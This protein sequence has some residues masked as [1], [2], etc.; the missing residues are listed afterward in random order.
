MA[1]HSTNRSLFITLIIT[2]SSC[3]SYGRDQKISPLLYVLGRYRSRFSTSYVRVWP[4][5]PIFLV[6]VKRRVS[7]VQLPGREIRTVKANAWSDYDD[8]N[9][10]FRCICMSNIDETWHLIRE[11]KGTSELMHNLPHQSRFRCGNGPGMLILLTVG[12]GS[13]YDTEK[14]LEV[15]VGYLPVRYEGFLCALTLAVDPSS[16]INEA[17]RYIRCSTATPPRWCFIFPLMIFS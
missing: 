4:A 8:Q 10:S 15:V 14:K 17:H 1:S 3:R 13:C 2:I 12:S 6:F 9:K 11:L 16:G 5:W 7:N